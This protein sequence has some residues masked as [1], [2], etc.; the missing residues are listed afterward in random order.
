MNKILIN[1]L[2]V[3]ACFF[4]PANGYAAPA[5]QQDVDGRTP[6][7]GQPSITVTGYGYASAPP[8]AARV[9][10]V[11]GYQFTFP[12]EGPDLLLVEPDVIEAV[13]DLLLERGIREETLKIN[14]LGSSLFMPTSPTSEISFTFDEPGG[15]HNFLRE[16]HKELQAQ[17]APAIQSIQVAFIVEDCN[18]LEEEAIL[19]AFA[20]AKM[21]ADRLSRLLN[22]PLGE[23]VVAVSEDRI[24]PQCRD[25]AFSDF[26]SRATFDLEN[27]VSAVE[28]GAMLRVSF[29]IER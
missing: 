14:L 13:R 25:Y 21:R 15:L 19:D 8:D 22:L 24:S 11:L 2:I 17:R 27:N 5:I 6:S 10:L 16:F 7:D 1:S 18:V 29:A 12:G 3:L 26:I 9:H 4:V 23:E 28:V 20:D